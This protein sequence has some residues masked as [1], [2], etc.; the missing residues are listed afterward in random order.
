MTDKAHDK[1]QRAKDRAA[2]TEQLG[3]E[4]G[5]LSSSNVGRA[6]RV[7]KKVGKATESGQPGK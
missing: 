3:W 4:W 2:T 7:G 6:G 5:R 1:T